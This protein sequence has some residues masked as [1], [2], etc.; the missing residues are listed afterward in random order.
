MKSLFALASVMMV[1]L[2]YAL[3]PEHIREDLHDRMQPDAQILAQMQ[4][5]METFQ[6]FIDGPER[7]APREDS[8]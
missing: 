4:D 2:G 5:E 3:C 8:Q 6:R 1:G 7:F